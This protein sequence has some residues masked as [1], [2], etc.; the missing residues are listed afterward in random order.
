MTP[1]MTCDDGPASCNGRPRPEDDAA[2]AATARDLRIKAV[3]VGLVEAMRHDRGEVVMALRAELA[4]LR[5]E[6][7]PVT[8]AEESEAE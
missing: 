8:A 3:R 7:G 1:R 2:K 5:G 6:A 4:G